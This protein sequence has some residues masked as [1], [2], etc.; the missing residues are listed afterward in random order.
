MGRKL[1]DL[2]PTLQNLGFLAGIQLLGPAQTTLALNGFQNPLESIDWDPQDK[3]SLGSLS[4]G[5][6]TKDLSQFHRMLQKS[7]LKGFADGTRSYLRQKGVHPLVEIRSQRVG[8]PASFGL[9]K[10]PNGLDTG[11]E[12]FD[13]RFYLKGTSLCAFQARS[14]LLSD[15]SAFL[16][17]EIPTIDGYDPDLLGSQDGDS[18]WPDLET[19]RQRMRDSLFADHFLSGDTSDQSPQEADVTFFQ[20]ERCYIVKDGRIIPVWRQMIR[21]NGAPYIVLGNQN[22]V[23]KLEPQYFT[24]DGTG[25][26]YGHNKTTPPTTVRNLVGLVGDGTLTS[27]WLKTVVPPEISRAQEASHIFNYPSTDKKI[28]EVTAFANAQDHLLWFQKLGFEWYGPK[29]LEVRIHIKPQN[30]ANNAL[31]EPGDET[32]KTPPTITIDDGDGVELQNLVTDGDVVSH[33]MGHHVIFRTLKSVSDQSLVLHEGLSDYFVFARTGDPCLGETI[34]PANSGQCMVPGKCLRSAANRLVFNDANWQQFSGTRSKQLGHLHGQLISGMMWDIRSSN[35]ISNDDLARLTLKAV[36]FFAESSNFCQFIRALYAAD[37]DLFAGKYFELIKFVGG[38]RGL[39]DLTDPTKE[40]PAGSLT[41]DPAKT[42]QT[43]ENKSKKESKSG[44]SCGTLP[45]K[46]EA[47]QGQTRDGINWSLLFLLSIPIA[48]I[49]HTKMKK[50]IHCIS[51]QIGILIGLV[52]SS[53]VLSPPPALATPAATSKAGATVPQQPLTDLNDASL[54]ISVILQWEGRSLNPDNIEAIET[55]RVQFPQFDLIHLLSPAYFLRTPKESQEATLALGRLV[56]PTDFY[57]MNLGGW[58]SLVTQAGVIFRSAPTFWGTSLTLGECR[59][60]CGGDVPLNI[61]PEADLEKIMD[62]SLKTLENKA[63]GK[64]RAMG[65]TGWVGSGVMMDLAT[66]HGL[67]YDFSPVPPEVLENSF[68]YYP[69]FGW[70]K[71]LWSNITPLTTPFFRTTTSGRLYHY[72]QSLG[73]IDH[74]SFGTLVQHLEKAVARWSLAKTESPP[75]SNA[76]NAG[77]NLTIPIVI[78]LETAETTVPRLSEELKAL[79]ALAQKNKVKVLKQTFADLRIP[80][81]SALVAAKVENETAKPLAVGSPQTPP[82]SGQQSP[83]TD[84]KAH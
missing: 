14:H 23:F 42:I 57:G 80:R 17:G 56:R 68:G 78:Y 64:P 28:E 33:E 50:R 38:E 8:Q 15:G 20:G 62:F 41:R 79:L 6:F 58:K 4:H 5:S 71:D 30:K 77:Q 69:L 25:T 45:G 7:S 34:C 40:C 24:V 47:Q 76:T 82:A 27:E 11:G 84:V 36:S 53:Q 52:G 10:V 55:L 26:A 59:N 9:N 61:Y 46:S 3:V 54:T 73:G 2:Y 37:K 60:D 66:K 67:S 65:I 81:P 19:T 63:L 51:R 35:Q 48:L 1:K 83:E 21:W 49:S 18:T 32:S 16:T 12:S 29:P 13:I 74:Q 22:D 44:I 70:T 31:F 43:S 75:L 39:G 72:P